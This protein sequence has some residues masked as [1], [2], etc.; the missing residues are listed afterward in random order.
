V[1]PERQREVQAA[2]KARNLERVKARNRAHAKR[3]A[4]EHPEKVRANQRRWRGIVDASGER[5]VGPCEICGRHADPLSL[6]HDHQ[7]GRARGWL[8]SSC[9]TGLG[10]FRDDPELLRK[11][12][13]YVEN[14]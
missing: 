7:T 2:Y 14:L 12:A 11:A 8:C 3:F 10:R 6:D 4:E 13:A 5:R 9:N 1:T